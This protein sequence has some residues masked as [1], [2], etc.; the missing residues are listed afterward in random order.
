MKIR[1]RLMQARFIEIY[2]VFAKINKVRY[3][4]K[5][6]CEGLLTPWLMEPGGPMLHSQGLFNNPYPEPNQPNSPH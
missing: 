3:V 2:Q 6:V 5:C 4:S 1:G